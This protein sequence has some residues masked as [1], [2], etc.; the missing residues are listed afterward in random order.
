MRII[1]LIVGG[2]TLFASNT[3]GAKMPLSDAHNY[4]SPDDSTYEACSL[5]FHIRCDWQIYISAY[6]ADNTT[7]FKL[8]VADE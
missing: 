2:L 7:L 4:Y 3:H 6:G 8:N 1:F 5:L